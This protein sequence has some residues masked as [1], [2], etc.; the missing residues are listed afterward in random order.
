[1]YPRADVHGNGASAIGEDIVQI[2]SVDF[3][4][5]VDMANHDAGLRSATGRVAPE[6]PRLTPISKASL[7]RQPSGGM[8]HGTTGRKEGLPRSKSGAGEFS[9]IGHTT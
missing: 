3:R 6:V 7:H 5:T 9:L 1:V 8:L 4:K 2:S